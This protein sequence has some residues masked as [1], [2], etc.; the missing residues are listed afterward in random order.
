MNIEN[1]IRNHA[2]AIFGPEH[3]GTKAILNLMIDGFGANGKRGNCGHEQLFEEERLYAFKYSLPTGHSEQGP[4]PSPQNI[5][6]DLLMAN[7]RKITVLIPTRNNW[8][9]HESHFRDRKTIVTNEMEKT[10]F[11]R[12]PEVLQRMIQSSY[13]TIIADCQLMGVPFYFVSYEDMTSNTL[14]FLRSLSYIL[15]EPLV[16]EKVGVFD[17]NAKYNPLLENKDYMLK[18][19]KQ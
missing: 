10:C 5:L 6:R 8:C 18:K 1:S 2:V 17:A 9:L 13:A 7:Y 19:E 16:S 11:F 12:H 3:T 4:F 15:D 14:R